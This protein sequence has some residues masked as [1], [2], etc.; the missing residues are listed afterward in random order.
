MA[1]ISGS[2]MGNNHSR[3]TTA[4][5][6]WYVD[7][8]NSSACIRFSRADRTEFGSIQFSLVHFYH[9]YI[10]CKC[11]VSDWVTDVFLWMGLCFKANTIFH[12]GILNRI[13]K[14]I[15]VLFQPCLFM[16]LANYFDLIE[17]LILS[18]LLA[19]LSVLNCFVLR[20]LL[21]VNCFW[22]SFS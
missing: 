5:I 17:F 8:V 10:V 21:F 7:L 13:M 19:C 3:N 6:E 20:Y 1:L 22:F 16:K 18:F 4:C 14:I 2:S 15:N 12:N 9:S 11:T